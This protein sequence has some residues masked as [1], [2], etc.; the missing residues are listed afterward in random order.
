MICNMLSSD[1]YILHMTYIDLFSK[2]KLPPSLI[3]LGAA[4]ASKAIF[5]IFKGKCIALA[6]YTRT[7]QWTPS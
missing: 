3:R 2:D 1:L 4:Y 7:T 6:S 5:R